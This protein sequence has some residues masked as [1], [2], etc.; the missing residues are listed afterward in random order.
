MTAAGGLC[1]KSPERPAAS[2]DRFASRTVSAT[3]SLAMA[4]KDSNVADLSNTKEFFTKSVRSGLAVLITEAI[5]QS[6]ATGLGQLTKLKA[7]AE[8]AGFCERFRE[9]KREAKVRFADWLQSTSG[10]T[11]DPDTIFD[12]QIE[13]IHEYKQQLLNALRIIA[14]NSSTTQAA[15]AIAFLPRRITR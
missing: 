2:P 12:Y 13:P 6:W 8:D 3:M 9:A 7:F 10:Q 15:T 14:P 4:M 1:W 5:G 11:V